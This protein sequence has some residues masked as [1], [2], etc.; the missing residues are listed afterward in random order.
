MSVQNVRRGSGV[1]GRMLAA[2]WMACEK[3]SGGED[4]LVSSES[5]SLSGLTIDSVLDVRS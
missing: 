3:K 5:S 4:W 1:E 2:S